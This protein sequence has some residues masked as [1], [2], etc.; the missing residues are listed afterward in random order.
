M[1]LEHPVATLIRQRYSCRSYDESPME[2]SARAR[3]VEALGRDIR[4]PFGRRAR[5][6][7]IAVSDE[8]PDILRGLGTYGFIKGATGYVAGAI[9][10]GPHY[11][12]EYGYVM[13]RIILLC[14]DL[15]MGS[16]WL[17][18]SLTKSRFAER[19]G[20]QPGEV[21]PAVASVGRIKEGSRE[22]DK[23]RKRAGS[24]RRLPPSELFFDSR[25]GEPISARDA[26]PYAEVLEM[27][28][29]APSASN[30]Q[31]WRIVRGSEGW[32]FYLQ[33]TKGY[34]K[35]T[36]LFTVLG[37]A[38]LQR[39]DMGISMC[40]FELMARELSL[41]GRWVVREPDLEKPQEGVEY[42]ATWEVP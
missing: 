1:E 2:E 26:G 4:G 3:L 41:P 27:V 24:D 7:L 17:G 10:E 35:G 9:E 39:V 14:T 15:G 8:D 30:R 13:E 42:I 23:I 5:F 19:I 22:R 28:R 38:D 29:L 34:G 18:G 16:C 33:R 6:T 25:F 36:I 40:H 37:L 11:L 20:L 31:P 21:M 12:E 32:H